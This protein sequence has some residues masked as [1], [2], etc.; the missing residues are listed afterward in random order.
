MRN[1]LI[2]EVLSLDGTPFFWIR[3]SE[4]GIRNYGWKRCFACKTRLVCAA[5]CSFV[6]FDLLKLVGACLEASTTDQTV[7]LARRN[8]FP[9]TDH[10]V[11]LQEEPH[12]PQHT[13]LVREDTSPTYAQPLSPAPLPFALE[14]KALIK[15]DSA[16]DHTGL[17]FKPLVKPH[18]ALKQPKTVSSGL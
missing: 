16:L 3:N 18:S 13:N 10:T 2:L 12:F 14:S 9:F 11:T 6:S 17:E 8:P 7:N 4:F 5:N 1:E 15:C